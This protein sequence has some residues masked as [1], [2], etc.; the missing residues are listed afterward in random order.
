MEKLNPI[1]GDVVQWHTQA[2]NITTNLRVK[3]DFTL[4]K[5][6]A[7]D[8]LTWNFHVDDS[9]K[10]RYDNF[11]GKELL[12]KLVLNLKFS[13][14]IIE[15]DNEILKGLTVHMVDLGAY[16]LKSKIQGKLHPNSFLWMLTQNK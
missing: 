12:A 9:S 2:G 10:G 6:S 1:K 15:A 8:F 5:L 14:H 7:T 3:I 11:L 16:I 4:P 13:E